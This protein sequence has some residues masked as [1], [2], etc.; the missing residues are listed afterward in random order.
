M[1]FSRVPGDSD[2]VSS[3]KSR[4]DQW[5]PPV[6]EGSSPVD[7]HIIASL[8]KLWYREL[9]E[10]LIPREFYASCVE[11]FASPQAAVEIVGQLPELNRLVLTY[12]IRFL[13]VDLCT[14]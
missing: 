9:H 12:L 13:Q 7:P 5:L 8:L 10:P 4:C 1:F 14:C 6:I 2:E 3:L 11:A